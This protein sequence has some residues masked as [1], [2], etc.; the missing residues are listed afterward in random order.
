M[1]PL[2]NLRGWGVFYLVKILNNPNQIVW[3]DSK[4]LKLMIGYVLAPF[5]WRSRDIS[6]ETTILTFYVW[7]SENDYESSIRT[8]A[9]KI[10]FSNSKETIA[11][12][13]VS[14]QNKIKLNFP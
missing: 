12:V 13:G 9:T 1:S 8:G 5:A 10:I 4:I 7:I 2:K 3:I 11:Y 14:V 6:R